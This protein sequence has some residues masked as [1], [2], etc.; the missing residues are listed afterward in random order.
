MIWLVCICTLGL[1]VRLA[2]LW[3]IARSA[4]PQHHL[5]YSEMDDQSFFIWAHTIMNGDWL[6]RATYHPYFEWM[7][8]IAPLET[9]EQWWGGRTIFHQPP[10]YPYLLAG[11]LT[12]CRD[13]VLCVFASQLLFGTFHI[14]ILYALG[15]RL[16][17]QTAGLLAAFFTALYGPFIFYET[18]LLRDWLPAILEPLAIACVLKA[19]AEHRSGLWIIAGASLGLAL[20]VK[21]TAL[22][23]LLLSLAWTIVAFRPEWRAG[24][25]AAA[26]LAAGFALTMTPLVLRN[27]TVDAPPFALSTRAAEVM[28]MAN[29]PHP[30][31]LKASLAVAMEK[32]E[33]H[34]LSAIRQTWRTYRNDWQLLSTQL[35]WKLVILK[36][37]FEFPN[38]VSFYYGMDI[39]PVLRWCI[40]YGMIV[41]LGLAGLLLFCRRDRN[42]LLLALYLVA[43]VG[44]LLMTSPLS[45]HRLSLVPPLLVFAAATLVAMLHAGLQ[46]NLHRLGLMAVLILGSALVQHA[47]FLYP[48]QSKTY[49]Y[50]PDYIASAR[51][52]AES[53]QYDRAAGEMSRLIDQAAQSPQRPTVPPFLKADLAVFQAQDLIQHDRR[54]EAHALL[55]HALESWA[56]TPPA[57]EGKPVHYPWF[58]FGLAYLKLGDKEKADDALTRF[59]ELDP[60]N[61]LADRARRLLERTE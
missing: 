33:G 24:F 40:T 38:N 12:F 21:E 56:G 41:P 55:D 20:L 58:N 54:A 11:L 35:G 39:S 10:L 23:L 1:T 36:D 59:I 53:K 8:E 51:A 14:L 19:R 45:R 9:W 30:L 5:M 48:E 52:Y 18:T 46:H 43:T 27:L 29:T 61:S 4:W 7:K 3:A 25:R 17:G 47:I 22:L 6:G 28:V 49:V 50:M 44:W 13:S 31:N 60:G 57:F 15:T 42:T 34:V 26:W 37:P 16:F 32:S 2:H